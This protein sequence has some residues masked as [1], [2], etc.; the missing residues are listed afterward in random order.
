MAI[1]YKSKKKSF[2]LKQE[3]D[4]YTLR[5]IERIV[6][7]WARYSGER[8]DKNEEGKIRNKGEIKEL[9]QRLIRYADNPETFTDGFEKE[10]E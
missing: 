9:A 5:E 2:K 6:Y 10:E 8:T 4:E 3:F 7:I 1:K